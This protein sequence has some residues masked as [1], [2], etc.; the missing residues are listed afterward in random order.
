MARIIGLLA[1]LCLIEPLPLGVLNLQGDQGSFVLID[2][3]DGSYQTPNGVVSG[4]QWVPTDAPIP[5]VGQ[6]VSRD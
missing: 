6:S 2:Y 4:I 5:S 1:D 3:S